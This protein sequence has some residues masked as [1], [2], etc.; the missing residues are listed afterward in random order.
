MVISIDNFPRTPQLAGALNFRDLGG[1]PTSAGGSIRWNCLFRSGTTHAM[2]D[3]DLEWLSARGIRFAYDL[4]S[5]GERIDHPNRLQ[6]IVDMSYRFLQH[7][8]IGGDISRSL[9]TT[10]VR[11]ED[12]R[13]MM[14]SFYKGLPYTFKDSYRALLLHLADGDL[15]MVFNCTA[16]KDRT[17][18]AAALI[19]TVLDVPQSVILDDYV[20]TDECFEQSCEMLLGGKYRAFFDGIPREVWEPLMRADPDYL[21]AALEQLTVSHGSVINYVQTELG[22]SQTEI[23]RIRSNLID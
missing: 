20:L 15:P 11:R 16:G 3:A 18:V 21:R 2:T 23:D 17:G 5:N 8:Q 4:R 14:V 9:R 1:Y 19:L 6:D 13:Q 7:D 22:L 10:D 12:A